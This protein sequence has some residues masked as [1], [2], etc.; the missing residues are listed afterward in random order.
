MG[1]G[2]GGGGRWC[3]ENQR[4]QYSFSSN[5]LKVPVKS[6]TDIADDINIFI[7]SQIVIYP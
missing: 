3:S 4:V 6:E 1:R 5:Q 7:E 2:G